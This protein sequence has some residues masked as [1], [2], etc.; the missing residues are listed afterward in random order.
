ML[1]HILDRGI[2]KG[3]LGDFQASIV[4]FNKGLALKPDMA[5]AYINRGIAKGAM[6]DYEGSIQDF[7][8]SLKLNPELA[9]AY[10]N[11]GLTE[12]FTGKKT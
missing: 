11:R 7:N 6:K 10:R 4:D 9:D 3:G 12:I 1:K 2:A 5:E 8:I